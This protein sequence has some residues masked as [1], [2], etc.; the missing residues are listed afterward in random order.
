M[1]SMILS[2]ARFVLW[3]FRQVHDAA[4]EELAQEGQRITTELGHL[5]SMLAAGQLSEAEFDEREK[6]L[7]D[8]LDEIEGDLDGDTAG[9]A[10][11]DGQNE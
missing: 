8:R 2:P 1:T 11:T 5:H 10:G 6:V 9:R 4:K 3:I 7:L